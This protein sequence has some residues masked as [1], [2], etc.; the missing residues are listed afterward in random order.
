[1]KWPWVERARLLARMFKEA[2]L[3]QIVAIKDETPPHDLGAFFDD[4]RILCRLRFPLAAMA[5]STRFRAERD[6]ARLGQPMLEVVLA[7]L[8]L[9]CSGSAQND[10]HGAT[11]VT[12]EDVLAFLIHSTAASYTKL[13]AELAAINKVVADL[14]ENVFGREDPL[15]SEVRDHLWIAEI[16]ATAIPEAWACVAEGFADDAGIRDMPNLEEPHP[17]TIAGYV[18]T[19][20]E[21]VVHDGW[22]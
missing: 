9:L 1:M 5:E 13:R 10:V 3:A 14:E 19:V 16:A 21:L 17:D 12:R 11:G 7:D 22:L 8:A 6:L 2:N 20:R 15:P 18:R 4:A